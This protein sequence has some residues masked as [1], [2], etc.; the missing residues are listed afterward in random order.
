MTYIIF[1]L[2]STRSRQ[3]KSDLTKHFLFMHS[4][5]S[6]LS[7]LAHLCFHVLGRSFC[8]RWL[9]RRSGGWLV[10]GRSRAPALRAKSH[11]GKTQKPKSRDSLNP[12]AAPRSQISRHRPLIDTP[13]PSASTQT[14]HHQT[15]KRFRHLKTLY[16]L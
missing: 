6:R 7:L 13:R 2:V 5:T 3:Q 10:G 16:R 11:Q 14:R 12:H 15:Q 9:V 4:D 8:R 1:I